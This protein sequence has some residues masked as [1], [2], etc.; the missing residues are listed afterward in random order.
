MLWNDDLD[1]FLEK[2]EEVEQKEIADQAE[3]VTGKA[4]K[5]KKKAF[6]QETMASPHGIR[7]AVKVSFKLW[8][9]FEFYCPFFLKNMMRKIKQPLKK[10]NFYS[11]S[12]MRVSNL[13]NLQ[14]FQITILSMKFE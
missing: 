13:Q 9:L 12:A 14:L 5:G 8:T 4:A 3:A 10:G 11:K 1:E 2:L 6:K 7:V